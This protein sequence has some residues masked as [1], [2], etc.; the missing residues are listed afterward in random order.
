[1]CDK[2][3]RKMDTMMIENTPETIIIEFGW[4]FNSISFYWLEQKEWMVILKKKRNRNS[5][6]AASWIIGVLNTISVALRLTSKSFHADMH[7]QR[8]RSY[9]DTDDN[10]L[11][12]VSIVE[13]IGPKTK[14][15]NENCSPFSL[16]FEILYEMNCCSSIPDSII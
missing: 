4:I 6:L 10:F 16:R 15:E 11:V 2:D 9:L 14:W 12:V 7:L 3:L 13:W 8:S 1:M 5:K